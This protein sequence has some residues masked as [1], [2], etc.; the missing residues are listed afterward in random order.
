MVSVMAY[1]C[2]HC[3]K[4]Y[5]R[6]HACAQHERNCWRNPNRVPKVGELFDWRD[7][8]WQEC[9]VGEGPRWAPRT[10]EGFGYIWD[11]AEWRPVKL[12]NSV[13]PQPKNPPE[14]TDW[15]GWEFGEHAPD[16]CER[17]DR[18]PKRYRLGLLGL[19]QQAPAGEDA[20]D[21]QG[22]G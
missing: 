16:L 15:S 2:S 14:G 20:T 5:L 4:V 7:F 18:W 19:E 10:A 9:L 21:A 11:G 6:R 12:T 1:R 3:G 13:W 8:S 17:L 22:G